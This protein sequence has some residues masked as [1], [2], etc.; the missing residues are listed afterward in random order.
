MGITLNA[1]AQSEHVAPPPPK[2]TAGV[3]TSHP[4]W[5]QPKVS[6]VDSVDHI[7]AALYDVISGP[8]HQARDWNRMRSLFLPEARLVPVSIVPGSPHLTTKPA[9]DVL[10]LTIDDYIARASPHFEADGFYEHGTHNVV[11]QFGNIVSVF[12]TY[13]SRHNLAETQPFA[14]GIN[15]IELLR[16]G[17]RY[18]IEQ[19]YWDSERDGSPIPARYLPAAASTA[20]EASR[21]TENFAGDWTGQL[22][23]R[24]YQSNERVFLPTWLAAEVAP[25]GRTLSLKYTYDDGP[26]K[27]VREELKLTLDPTAKTATTTSDGEHTAASYA[28]AGFEDFAKKNRG[29]LVLTGAGKDN[30]K[31]ADVRVT[32]TLYRNLLTWVKETRPAGS[33]EDYKFRDAYTMT[34]SVAPNLSGGPIG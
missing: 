34:R 17:D 5:P 4:G 13:E 24:D 31:P 15:T 6:D 20:P 14:R 3:I 2:A 18:W 29:K 33:S 23:Y 8:A 21:P 9:T 19:V 7:L 27:V 22:E 10:F 26:T 32:L 11:E 25:D 12:S 1:T 30:D 16:D 28:V